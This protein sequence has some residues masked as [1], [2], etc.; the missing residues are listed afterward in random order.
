MTPK[1]GS[2]SR[3]YENT[4]RRE[5]SE[6]PLDRGTRS[7]RDPSGRRTSK[8]DATLR[9]ASQTAILRTGMDTISETFGH[10]LEQGGDHVAK[11]HL[12][13]M[14]DAWDLLA[15]TSTLVARGSPHADG[16]REVCA[17]AVKACEE[18]CEEFEGDEIMTAC[19]DVCREAYEHLVA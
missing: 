12:Q 15:A 4:Q 7:R 19:A 14:M 5:R 17:E 3:S 13:C 9:Q 16:L 1:V 11:E 2:T 18:S 8:P 6:R 10:C